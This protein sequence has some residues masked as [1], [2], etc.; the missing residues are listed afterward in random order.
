MCILIQSGWLCFS[1][2]WDALIMDTCFSIFDYVI[3]WKTRAPTRL[4]L[5][6]LFGELIAANKFFLHI[7]VWGDEGESVFSVSGVSLASGDTLRAQLASSVACL[8]V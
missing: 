8:L 5:R 2:C 3:R 1:S 7:R 4:V 6:I